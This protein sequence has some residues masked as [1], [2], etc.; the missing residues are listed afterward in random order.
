MVNL[1]FFIIPLLLI[2]L[3][4]P[5]PARAAEVTAV[6]DRDRVA[7]GES[8]QLQLRVQGRPDADPDLTAL[9][10][11]WEILQ[12]SQSSQMRIINGDFSRTTVWTLSLMPRHAGEVAIPPVCFGSDCSAALPIRVTPEAQAGP[13]AAIG[14]LDLQVAVEPQQIVAG[15]QLLLTVRL[16]RRVE[17]LQASLTEPQP[18]GVETMVRKLGD[19][20]SYESRI[21]GRRYQVIERRYA[22]FPQ[23]AGTL[24]LPAIQFDGRIVTGGSRFD[25]FGN[26]S[27]RVR[28]HS[29]P[30]TVEI[31]PLPGDA[32]GRPWLPTQKL[33]LD[34]SWPQR[35][36]RMTVGEPVTRTLTLQAMGLPAAQLPELNLN[37]PE[38]FKSYP[39]QPARDD[40][41]G[42]DG[43]TGTLRQKIALVATRPGRFSLPAL[44]LDWWDTSAQRWQTAHLDPV[45]IEV[46][47]AAGTV[48]ATPA[49][50][51]ALATDQPS[52][53]P[54]PAA[55]KADTAAP[56]A[57][58][59]PTVLP[60]RNTGFWPW[61][62]LGLG[63]G[64][65]A[66]LLLWW[67]QNRRPQRAGPTP[68]P[69]RR[70]AGEKRPPGPGAGGPRQRCPRHPPGPGNLEPRPAPA[71]RAGRPGRPVRRSARRA[72]R[73]DRAPQPRPVRPRRTTLDRHRPAAGPAPMAAPTKKPCRRRYPARAV[74]VAGI[75]P[76]IPAKPL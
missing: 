55:A 40:Q 13:Q 53:A 42:V 72:A 4:L 60:V 73:G 68:P 63:L 46:A 8:L 1:R 48:A 50:P 16:L 7:L 20:R 39:D 52:P 49:A 15:S 3:M 26:T 25:P 6:A 66:T 5:C 29:R 2:L 36:V 35:P 24:T 59:A 37:V 51:T 38:G 41:A 43:L 64:W 33:T 17:L 58:A 34:D 54:A 12:R 18:E 70:A 30:I 10:K 9:E 22:L 57:A 76:F 31:Q 28:K 19:D 71:A 21:D 45:E 14:D 74:S 44:D 47:P 75:T 56:S 27:R 62:A 11:D 69:Q 61:L 65:L 23:A 32:N 67:R